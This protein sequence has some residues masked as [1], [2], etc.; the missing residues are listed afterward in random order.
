VHI[1]EEENYVGGKSLNSKKV[2]FQDLSIF[3]A[4][5]LA[6]IAYLILYFC[7]GACYPWCQK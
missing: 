7:G 1:E 4:F 5:L 6:F 2:S 3:H